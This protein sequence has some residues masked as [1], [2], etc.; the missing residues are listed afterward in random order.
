ME[1]TS[2]LETK[3]L[4]IA[5]AK[6]SD[7]EKIFENYW[8][9]KKTATYMLWKPQRNLDEAKERLE[10]TINFQKDHLAFFVYEKYSGEPIG[11][12]AFIEVEDGTFEDGGIGIG[13]NFVGKGYGKQILT[14]FINYLFQEVGANKIVCSCHTDNMPSAKMQLACGMKYSYSKMVTREK[15]GLTYKSDNY[16]ITRDE[17]IENNKN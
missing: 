9:S 6:P 2:S 7:L 17:W 15:D 14:C 4:I 1:F 8:C 3:D 13:E 16:V 11:Q 12:V 10:R 5:K